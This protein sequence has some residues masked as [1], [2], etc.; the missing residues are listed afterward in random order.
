M[1]T[2]NLLHDAVIARLRARRKGGPVKLILEAPRVAKIA[3]APM[4]KALGA[5][6]K[7]QVKQL[8]EY[9]AAHHDA[10]RQALDG[11]A[12]LLGC[13]PNTNAPTGET[14]G[15]TVPDANPPRSKAP[16]QKGNASQ[17]S[18]LGAKI[19]GSLNQPKE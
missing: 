11:V 2:T 16:A 9:A 1:N 13:G 17:L 3:S 5:A 12:A 18:D 4:R 8:L 10:A 14:E 15:D 19:Y 6:D 7:K